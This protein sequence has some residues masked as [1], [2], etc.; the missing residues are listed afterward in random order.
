MTGKKILG[1]LENGSVPNAIILLTFKE[2]K[3]ILYISNM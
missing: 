3:K 1:Y 2:E